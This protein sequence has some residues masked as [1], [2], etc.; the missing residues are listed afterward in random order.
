MS[1]DSATGLTYENQS[2][3]KGDAY[4][5][6]PSRPVAW[7]KASGASWPSISTGSYTVTFY[8]ARN[9][10]KA[11]SGS[12]TISKACT[13]VSDS[14]VH[15]FLT[16]AE[17]DALGTGTGAYDYQLVATKGSTEQWTLAT[18]TLSVLAERIL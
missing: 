15:L 4:T 11:T 18:G 12:A 5:A 7:T 9:S 1:V 2:V 10:S 6:S 13:V 16:K 8:A 17:T 14:V 3:V